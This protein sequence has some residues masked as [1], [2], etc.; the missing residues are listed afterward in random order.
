MQ[1]TTAANTIEGKLYSL[2][3]GDALLMRESVGLNGKPLVYPV[4]VYANG[5]TCSARTGRFSHLTVI[6]AC[7]AVRR[8]EAAA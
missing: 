7:A 3:N 1:V 6:P 2:T 5:R 4:Y 8:F